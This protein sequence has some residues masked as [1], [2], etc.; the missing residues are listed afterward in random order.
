MADEMLMNSTRVVF[1]TNGREDN[2]VCKHENV[3][4]P[5]MDF[6]CCWLVRVS[7]MIKV[8]AR[9]PKDVWVT[10]L[11]KFLPSFWPIEILDTLYKNSNDNT[12]DVMLRDSN[13]ASIRR[14]SSFVLYYQ[15]GEELDACDDG[16]R[17][18]KRYYSGRGCGL[19]ADAAPVPVGTCKYPL[20]SL[21]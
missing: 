5:V 7:L 21:R 3:I 9:P 14:H 11:C 18:T 15:E 19:Q 10:N 13:I 6:Y 17:Y 2:L 4:L 16:V 8:S 1:S 20:S 12:N